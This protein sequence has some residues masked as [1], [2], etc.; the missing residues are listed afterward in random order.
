MLKIFSIFIITILFSSFSQ[1]ENKDKL[2]FSSVWGKENKDELDFSSA[3]ETEETKIKNSFYYF[4]NKEIK[5]LIQ[6]IK[7]I[8]KHETR[9]NTSS[10]FEADIAKFISQIKKLKKGNKNLVINNDQ[11]KIMVDFS[12]K[13]DLRSLQMAIIPFLP[14]HIAWTKNGVITPIQ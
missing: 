3:W 4:S 13:N 12:Q 11:I 6:K 5:K 1:E 10:I 8:K 9:I 2:D 14:M 7:I